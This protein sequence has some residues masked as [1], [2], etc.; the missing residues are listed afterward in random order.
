MTVF[1]VYSKKVAHQARKA[2]IK[3]ASHHIFAKWTRRR[4]L[5]PQETVQKLSGL[6]KV[7]RTDP[8]LHLPTQRQASFDALRK[9]LRSA[10]LHFWTVPTNNVKPSIVCLNI[11]DR[12]Q[13]WRAVRS[14]KFKNWYF[15]GLSARGELS[16]RVTSVEAALNARWSAGRIWENVIATPISNFCAGSAQGVDVQ[17]WGPRE[18]GHLSPPVW[19]EVATSL[20]ISESKA[21]DE[22]DIPTVWNHLPHISSM[23]RDID[24]VYTWVNGSDPSWLVQ[25]ARAEGSMDISASTERAQ[26]EARFADHEELRYSIRSIDQFAPWVRKIWIVTS[27]QVPEWL[28]TDDPKVQIVQHEE[29]WPNGDGLPNFNSHA[30]EACLHRIPGLS[31]HF[32]Y[33]NDDMILGR[34][35]APDLFFHANGVGKVFQSRALVDHR[36]PEPGEIASST[37]AKNARIILMNDFGVVQT[38][39]FYHTAASL[40]VS[41]LQELE[42]RYPEIFAQTRSA[43]FRTTSDVAVA[44][45]LYLNYAL[46]SGWSVPGRIK[47][48]YVDPATPEGWSRLRRVIDGRGYD[49]FCLND[50]STEQ[51]PEDRGKTDALIRSALEEYL[52][53]P[54][55]YERGQEVSI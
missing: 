6:P 21:V 8:H 52:P 35:V 18:D 47:Y 24:V 16:A 12:A 38:R 32:I 54:S 49:T 7:C 27:G 26:D 14:S 51:P 28:T 19:N 40:R 22:H 33:L 13:F 15:S 1:K 29:I 11:E 23:R 5:R 42:D 20:S 53:V 39:K 46:A 10:N 34:P 50:G 44:G 30:I 41:A 48:E 25:K 55:R 43:T 17:F 31:E 9:L 3:H 2:A 4:G 36:P 37:A 45:S